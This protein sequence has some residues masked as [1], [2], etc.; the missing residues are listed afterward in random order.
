MEKTSTGGVEEYLTLPAE[1][2]LARVD[3]RK[4]LTPLLK[5]TA[6]AHALIKIVS[7]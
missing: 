7:F 2:T 4:N 5:P 6:L 3:M 1:S